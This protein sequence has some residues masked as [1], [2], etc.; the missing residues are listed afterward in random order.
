MV[1]FISK[2]SWTDVWFFALVI[3][4]TL[5][6]THT[7]R[8]IKWKKW[9]DCKKKEDKARKKKEGKVNMSLR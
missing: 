7:H 6:K 2:E 4:D 8:Q 1:T 9:R 5:S 3:C